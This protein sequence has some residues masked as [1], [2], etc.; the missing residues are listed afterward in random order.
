MLFT[1]LAVVIVGLAIHWD[2]TPAPVV[3]TPADTSFSVAKAYGQLRQIANK[4]HS[5][6]TVEKERVRDYILAQ[7][8]G[9]GLSTRLQHSTSVVSHLTGIVAG[10]VTNIIAEYKGQDS[11]QGPKSAL[12]VMAHYDSQP[13]A[14]GAGDDGAGCAA[15]LETARLIKTGRPLRNNIIFLFTDGEETGLLGSTSFVRDDSLFSQVGAVLNFDGRGN[16]GKSFMISNGSSGWMVGEYARFCAH[17][18]A[19]SLYHEIFRILPNSTDLLPFS[20]QGIP[21]FDFA[22]IDGF[23]NYH[24]MTDQPVNMDRNTLQDH[25]DN[26]LSLVKYFG[27]IDLKQPRGTEHTFFNALGNWMIL[28]PVSWN[29]F[30]LVLTNLLLLTWLVMGIINRRIRWQ[31]ALTGFLSFSVALGLLYFVTS[32]SL[33]G[34]RAA[35]PLYDD[36]YSNAYNSRYFYFAVIMLVIAVFTF[37]YQGLQRKFDILSLMAGIALVLT[38]ILDGLYSIIPTAIYF[39]CFPLL[40][41]LIACAA[42]GATRATGAARAVVWRTTALTFAASLPALLL[43]APLIYGLF[44]GFDIQPEAAALGPLTGILLGLLIPLFAPVFRESRWSIPGAA[45]L[46]CLLA[47]GFGVL[48]GKYAAGNPYKTNLRYFANTDDSVAYWVLRSTPVDAWNRQF[49]PHPVM[50][51]SGYN[52]AGLRGGMMEE[53]VNKTVFVNFSAPDIAVKSDSVGNGVRKLLLHCMVFDSAA[54]AHFDLDSSCP[55]LHVA[56]NGVRAL[57]DSGQQKYRWVD[58]SG[59]WPDGFDIL[60]ELDPKTPFKFHAISR[61]MG[62]PGIQG[63]HGY[64]LEMIP[65]PGTFSNTTMASKFYT[66]DA[67]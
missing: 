29:L 34:V 58:V 66:F 15:M 31:G 36:Y 38:I 55:A 42:T 53:T 45:F 22:Y 39:L 5:L 64:P 43:L 7:C 18:S 41:V 17:K 25:G 52:F 50:A 14:V 57:T 8:Q 40:F 32:F 33:K 26:M 54:S 3:D 4:P 13:N 10:N 30:F 63:F 44:I 60:F 12:L 23:V 11:L 27:S 24:A 2:F 19:S 16:S 46:L 56:I 48:H 35:Y 47:T 59:I 1:A 67:R 62:L 9:L 6:G 20:Q 65:G 61:I 37:I 21:G 28:F 49:F 51:R